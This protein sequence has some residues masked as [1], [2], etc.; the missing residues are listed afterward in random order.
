MSAAIASG[1][2]CLWRLADMLVV[3]DPSIMRPF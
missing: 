1:Q 3:S 2:N